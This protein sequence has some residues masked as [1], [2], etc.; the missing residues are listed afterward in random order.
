[1]TVTGR[2]CRSAERAGD[3]AQER[4]PEPRHRLASRERER[5]WDGRVRDGRVL[6]ERR[7]TTSKLDGDSEPSPLRQLQ[8]FYRYYLS[9]IHLF[10]VHRALIAC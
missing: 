9:F 3:Q 7:E 6:Q 4:L 5:L 1:M 8:T 10:G 2:R